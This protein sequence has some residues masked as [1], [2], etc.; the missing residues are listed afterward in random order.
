MGLDASTLL[1]AGIKR[2]GTPLNA[3]R[4]ALLI[5]M[6]ALSRPIEVELLQVLSRPRRARFIDPQLREEVIGQSLRDAVR[7][8]PTEQAMDCRDAKDNKCVELAA[9]AGAVSIVSSDNDLLVLDPWRGVRI[10]RPA[11]YLALT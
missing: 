4:K 2:D 11:E 7:F 1:G 5:D 10:V 3:L 8:V 9:V 6:L